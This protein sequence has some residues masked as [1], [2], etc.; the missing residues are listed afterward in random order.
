MSTIS[1]FTR[2][3][4]KAYLEVF[5]ERTVEL[6][7][8][9]QVDTFRSSAEY[10]SLFSQQGRLKPFHA[11]LLPN[12]VSGISSFER[13]LS[14]TMGTTFEECALLIA[15]DH[16][17]IAQRGYDLTGTINGE[18][19]QVIEEQITIRERLLES[20]EQLPTLDQMI[21]Q[22]LA[23]SSNEP[24][25]M[26]TVRVDLFVQTYDG[27]E[28]YFELK[29]PVPNKGQCLEVTQRIL[30]IHALRNIPRPQV[31]AYF[32][33]AYN[34]Y[35]STREY[36][37]W[38]IAQKYLPFDQSVVIGNEFWTLIGGDTTYAELLDIYR[39]VGEQKAKY[40]ID[41]LAFGF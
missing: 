26:R 31:Q 27:R 4:I 32:A 8:G 37:R 15:S 36:Y 14:T 1:A 22:V 38:S 33:M 9:R 6:H 12:S 21:E 17:A 11:A 25:Q 28:F 10:L 19:V 23:R 35:G 7:R 24:K 41:A 16:H 30:R 2:E 13:S 5:I 29:S 3:K 20:G 40:I 34:P 18:T 39:E